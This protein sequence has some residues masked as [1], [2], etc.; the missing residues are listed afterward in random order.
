[1]FL[2]LDDFE[3]RHRLGQTVDRIA[4]DIPAGL[5]QIE[6]A[7]A[8][9]FIP[10]PVRGMGSGGRILDALQDTLGMDPTEFAR[11]VQEFVAEA[12]RTPGIANVFTTF[13]AATPQITSTSI[14]TRR[15]C[16]RVPVTNIFEAMRVFMGSAYVNDFNMFGRTYQRHGAGRRRLPLDAESVV[17]D[18]RAQHR[19]PDGATRQ[20]RD[21]QG[22]RRPRACAALQSVSCR[23]DQRHGEAGRQLGPVAGDH[24]RVGARKLPQGV[25]F[26]WTDLSYQE[27]K[28]GRTGYYIFVLSVH[29]RVPRAYRRNTRAGRCRSPSC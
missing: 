21:L 9:V 23:R 1:M 24:A 28:V 6:E 5:A 29:L 13:Q 10:P 8:F 27:A 2:V 12:N 3:E 15:R 26:E 17:E 16:S 18:P 7:Q 19:G 11:I 4:Q 20:P 22:D 25:T 14:A